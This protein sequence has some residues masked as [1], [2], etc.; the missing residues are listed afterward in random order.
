MSLLLLV[1]G[2]ISLILV[3][4]GR[5]ET[6]F[7]NVYLPCL[8]LLPQDYLFRIPHLPA[9]SV[10]DYALI[11]LG[12]VGLSRLI[13]SG[14]FALMDVL[15]VLYTAS[16]GLSEILHAPVL[17]DGI[18][19]AIVAFVTIF[20]AYTTGRRLIE[21]DLR[22]AT[23]RRFVIFVLLDAAPGMY[24]WKM[25][26]S[27]Y[28]LV[29]N[30]VLGISTIVESVQMRNGHGRMSSVFN[31]SEPGGIA[32]AMAFCL[33]AWLA[34]LRRVKA[35]VD[36]GKTLATLEKYHLSELILIAS[37]WFT[38]ARG[39]LI[40]LAAS[41]LILQIPR[42]KKTRLMTC[43]VAILLVGG[44][45][46]TKAYFASYA[47][48][49]DY[50]VSSEQQGSAQYRI[51]MNQVYAP[52]AE[53]GGWTGWG[54]LEIPHVQGKDSIDNHYLLVHLAW[55]RLGYIFFILIVWENI[56]VLLVRSWQFEAA[57]DRAFVFS[58]MAAMAV[59]WFTLLTV[60][61][62]GQLP[63]ISF[64][65]IGWIQSMVPGV[66]AT[67]SGAQITE[68]LNRKFSFRQVFT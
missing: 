14:S 23:I 48:V 64:L 45:L 39:P 40:A 2:L 54:V 18:F 1:P 57:Q 5:I 16:I 50:A 13:R 11:P 22:F 59:L 30:R 10:A 6:A 55:G 19:S 21:P 8:L 41:Y 65:L 61:M 43:I 24:E 7:L 15:V 4:R 52:I 44:Y 51:I 47:N 34:Y 66:A 20:L 26:Q 42:F 28:G 56:R 53:A 60:F 33:N 37:V 58:M 9:F 38:Q 36:L 3:V 17:N 27:L 32:F 63:Q 25:G 67:S 12:V 35:R 49:A 68:N 29:G 46:E 31:G 62:G